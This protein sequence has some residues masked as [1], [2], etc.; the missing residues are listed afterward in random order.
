MI[1]VP[2][3]QK[4]EITNR[5]GLHA[6]PAAKFVKKAVQFESK[7][8]IVFEGKEVNAKNIMG[9]TSLGVGQGNEILIKTEGVDESEAIQEL[10]DFINIEL[11]KGD[12]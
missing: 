2:K 5:T 3:E 8:N 11:P 9:I 1:I 7:V 10:V 6:N 4:V 12:E